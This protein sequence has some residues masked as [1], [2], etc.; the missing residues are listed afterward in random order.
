MVSNSNA[1]TWSSLIVQ[2]F[3]IRVYSGD[4]EPAVC[5]QPEG[6]G[7]HNSGVSDGFPVVVEFYD[8]KPRVHVWADINQEDATHTI[9]LDGALESRRAHD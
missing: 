4:G 2:G 8:G 7:D 9:E 3:E 1:G 6:T 5:I